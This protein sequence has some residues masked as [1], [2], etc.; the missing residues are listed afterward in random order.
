V[1]APVWQG[2]VV[3]SGPIYHSRPVPPA[4]AAKRA[5][6]TWNT[7]TFGMIMMGHRER[8]GGGMSSAGGER[9]LFPAR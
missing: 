4:G 5:G 2:Q 8:A 1:D 7:H 6:M 3:W 9:G